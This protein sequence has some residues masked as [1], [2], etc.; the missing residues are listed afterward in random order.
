MNDRMAFSALVAMAS[1]SAAIA[2]GS[3]EAPSESFKFYQSAV[4]QLRERLSNESEPPGDAVM[5]TLSNLCGFE[6]RRH[7]SSFSEGNYRAELIR[8]FAPGLVGKL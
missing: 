2:T 1:F 7:L 4:S 3:R 8:C 5:I 6:V